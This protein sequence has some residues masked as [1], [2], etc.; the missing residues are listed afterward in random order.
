MTNASVNDLTINRFTSKDLQHVDAD[1]LDKDA[2]FLEAMAAFNPEI[3][4]REKAK[5]KPAAL[6]PLDDSLP[7][8]M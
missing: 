7:E 1:L 8:W 4:H 5:K 2:G 6:E 3:V